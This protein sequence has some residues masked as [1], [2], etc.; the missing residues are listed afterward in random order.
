MGF[1]GS[2]LGGGSG[3]GFQAQVD[4][5]AIGN[6]Q[7]QQ[8][9]LGGVEGNLQQIAAGNGPNPYLSQLQAATNQNTQNAAGLVASQKGLNP[10]LA[11]RL[12]GMN[13]A[14]SNQSAANTATGLQ[15]QQQLGA[16]NDLGQLSLGQQGVTQ[17]GISGANAANAGIAAQ[18]AKGQFGLV[19]GVAG[20]LPVVGG[21][22]HAHGGMIEPMPTGYAMGGMT[23]PSGPQSYL[24]QYL[25]PQ[26]M[27]GDESY[28]S[29]FGLGQNLAKGLVSAFGPKP[30][31]TAEQAVAGTPEMAPAMQAPS[32]P[33]ATMVAK[34]GGNVPGSAEVKG[35][36]PKNDTVPAVLSP[37]EIVIPRSILESKNPALAA[38]HFVEQELAKRPQKKSNFDEGGTTFSDQKPVV[39]NVNSAPAP[40]APQPGTGQTGFEKSIGVP[41]GQGLAAVGHVFAPYAV[42][43]PRMTAAPQAPA[44]MVPSPAPASVSPGLQSSVLD[45]QLPSNNSQAMPSSDPFG[46]SK[47]YQNMQNAF[48][49][50]GKGIEQEAAA[51]GA[52]GK[53]HA[54]I[55]GQKQLSLQNLQQNYQKNYDE[56]M[57]ERQNFVNDI[58][59]THINPNHYLANADTGTKLS[60]VL[61]LVLGGLGSGGSGQ[62]NA[63]Q[64][65]L[66]NQIDN[67]IK[68][69]Q[70]NLDTKK[71]LLSANFQKLGSMTDA[72]K[73]TK[74]NMLDDF[75]SKLQQSADKAQDP[76]VK[77]RAMQAK[78][79][80]LQQAAPIQQQM[81]QNRAIA[82]GLTSGNVDPAELVRRVLPKEEHDAAF[83]DLKEYQDKNATRDNILSAFNTVKNNRTL[84]QSPAF[85]SAAQNAMN[86]GIAELSKGVTGR[87]NADE[88]KQLIKQ[89]KPALFDSPEGIQLRLNQMNNLLSQNMHYPR[90]QKILPFIEKQNP[91]RFDKSGTNKIKEGI[92]NI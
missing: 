70:A 48:G 22:F 20:A 14:Q 39:V 81:A 80:I 88:N 25:K 41:A 35:D 11:A 91:S 49:M 54:A 61:G 85:R 27:T 66:N 60:T 13:A 52:L 56:I 8:G 83:K 19:N 67:D 57:G 29:G 71:T 24:T 76:I 26:V 44:P 77:A 68:A 37:G 40:S 18:N 33:M 59:N 73:M 15:A 63:A 47:Y 79:A 87:F 10:A 36:S 16:I 72:M 6:L 31:F 55:E 2:M 21:L 32:M 69:Q 23:T 53:E 75:A 12:A 38:A 46:D 64:Q 42:P 5:N 62:A 43:D 51:T 17:Q 28:D 34:D 84:F 92:P 45:K 30:Q 86:A 65:Y 7:Q 1:I 89:F 90:L 50:A 3:A 78:A 74:L 82:G 4:P 9:V 58:A